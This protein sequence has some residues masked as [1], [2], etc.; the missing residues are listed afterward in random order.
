MDKKEFLADIEEAVNFR[1]KLA[2]KIKSHNLPVLIF[3]AGKFAKIVTDELTNL[4]VEISGYALDEPDY[5]TS[6]K[7]YL[8]R[9]VYNFDE[10]A[11][12]DPKK[13]VFVL[14]VGL[15]RDTIEGVTIKSLRINNFLKD[16]RII[17]YGYLP[18]VNGFQLLRVGNSN[19]EYIKENLD[20]FFETYNIFEDNFSRK[21]MLAYLKGDISGNVLYLLDFLRPNEWFN[22]LNRE[23]AVGGIFFDCGAYIGDTVEKFINFTGG[24]Y[25]KIFAIEADPKNFAKL[26][27]FVDEKNYKNVKLVNCG[28]WNEKGTISFSSCGH[29]GSRIIETGD[30][31]V[32]TDTIDNILNNEPVSLIKMNIEG[33]EL[34]ALKGAVNTMQK[35]R[36]ALA[37]STYHRRED[38]I[39]LPQFIKNV[40]KNC[41]IYLRMNGT[42]LVLHGYFELYVKPD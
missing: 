40:Y 20:K 36:P 18:A 19:Y 17:S 14:G 12:T 24:N 26:E 30:A 8:G 9:P 2:E 7:T 41:K 35:F 22:E 37:I 25:K 28:V 15:Y 23:F 33:A 6:P 21:T 11:D 5:Y 29:V 10:L 1:E 39:T 4:G 3:G 32:P 13:Y 38:L 16:P 34:N 31:V 27:K 42:P